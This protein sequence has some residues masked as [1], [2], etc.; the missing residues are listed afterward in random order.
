MVH[1]A[2]NYAREN[3]GNNG[4]KD[5]FLPQGLIGQRCIASVFVEDIECESLLDTGSQVT[6]ISETLYLTHFSSLPIQPIHA[7]FEV[8]G[9][10]GQHVPYLGYIQVV[11]TFPC[12]VIGAEVELSSLVLVVPDCHFNSRVPLLIGTNV[13]DRLYQQ[14]VE[15]KGSKFFQNPGGSSDYALLF[16]HVAQNYESGKQPFQVRA[17]G[18]TTSLSLPTENLYPW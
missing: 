8:E 7:L 16:Q 2:G 9:A 5:E 4:F 6:T 15:R 11:I 17:L 14:E 1:V 18:K 13:L 3:Q 12:T 10:G